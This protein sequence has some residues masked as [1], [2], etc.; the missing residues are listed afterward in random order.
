MRLQTNRP[1]ADQIDLPVYHPDTNDVIKWI[2]YVETVRNEFNL[3]DLHI[4]MRVG[5]FLLHNANRWYERWTH[6]FHD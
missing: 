6:N 3:Y 2:D 4:L 5:R 1:P